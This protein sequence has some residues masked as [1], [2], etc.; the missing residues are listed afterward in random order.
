M[1]VE[2]GLKILKKLVWLM[3]T[4]FSPFCAAYILPT[5]GSRVQV[6]QFL[7][8]GRDAAFYSVLIKT[9]P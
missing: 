9:L 6:E 3:T 4:I 5:L 8:K 7:I 2:G 1:V